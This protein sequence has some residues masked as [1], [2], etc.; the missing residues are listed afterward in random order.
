[1]PAPG[2]HFQSVLIIQEFL[3]LVTR[4][5]FPLTPLKLLS[6]AGSPCGLLPEEK[7]AG[8]QARGS[9]S[10]GHDGAG[11]GKQILFVLHRTAMGM[12]SM[13]TAAS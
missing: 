8:T 5:L 12:V 9:S 4:R 10:Q 1:M 11:L 7:H 2:W 3:L 13:V 6:E